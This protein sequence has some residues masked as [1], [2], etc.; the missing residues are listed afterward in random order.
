MVKDINMKT[1]Q[2]VQR[3]FALISALW[4]GGLIAIGYFVVPV[5][6][7]GL[8]DRK[9]AGMVAGNLFRIEAYISVG[10]CVTLMVLAN[11]LV[12]RGLNQY[13]PIRWVLLAM[14]A[15][16][17]VASFILIPWMESVRNAASVEGMSVMLS[18]SAA[19]F[20]RLHVASSLLFLLESLLGVFLVWR[21]T[22]SF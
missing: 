20:S 19:L 17:I 14:W 21:I 15:C 10:V 7:S 5:L 1:F 2:T 22:K 18:S 11:L 12:N 8:L 4:V 16:S 6:F 13:R 3:V 9:I